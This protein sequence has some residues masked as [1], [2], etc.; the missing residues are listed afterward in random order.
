MPSWRDGPA[1]A[2][3]SSSAQSSSTTT[4]SSAPSKTSL[5]K[6]AA[7]A[8]ASRRV[9]SPSPIPG[10]SHSGFN[11]STP[12]P[13]PKKARSDGPASLLSRI[14]AANDPATPGSSTF[15]T[16]GPAPGTGASGTVTPRAQFEQQEDFIS[17]DASPPPPPSTGRRSARGQ[18]RERDVYDVDGSNRMKDREEG[19]STP[20]CQT[21]GVNWN[22]CRNATQT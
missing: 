9:R 2:A 11:P 20:W 14:A 12:A 8:A 7:A 5:R 4:A 17:F 16:P 21:P 18:K 15:G 3:A 1:P 13:L 6:Q 22:K 19:R 10:P